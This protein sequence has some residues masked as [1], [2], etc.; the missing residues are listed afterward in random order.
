MKKALLIPGIGGTTDCWNPLFTGRLQSRFAVETVELPEGAGTIRE[1][2]RGFTLSPPPDIIIGFSIGAAVVQE[3]LVSPSIGVFKAV[4]MAPPAGNRFPGPPKS[5]HDFSDGRGRWSATML[6][7]MF[8]PE[9]LAEHP[10]V[11]EF[12]PRVKRSV[13]GDSLKA[14]S[15]AINLWEGCLEGLARVTAPVLILAG[16]HDIIT[17]EV[18]ARA[19]HEALPCSRLTFMETGHGFPWQCPIETADTVLEFAQ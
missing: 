13:P 5:A 4:L 15:Q 16:L 14:Q 7:M 6:E 19:L 8:T 9:W 18:H 12:F 1:M 10:D 11:T 2:A 17:P 3:M